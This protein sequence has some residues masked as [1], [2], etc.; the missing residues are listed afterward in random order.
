MNKHTLKKAAASVVLA[1]ALA[2]GA[3]AVA[4]A[5]AP[6]PGPGS[7]DGA[8]YTIAPNG[9]VTIPFSGFIPGETVTVTLTGISALSGQIT[10]ASAAAGSESLVETTSANDAGEVTPVVTVPANA[11]GTYTVTAVGS[12]SGLALEAT[13]TIVANAGGGAGGGDDGTLPATGANADALLGLWVGGGALLLAGGAVVVAT[14]VRR[15]RNNS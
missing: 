1:G 8:S 2:L 6:S 14:S 3:P 10:F 13:I 7:G 5:Y 4:N 15:Q 12:E 9:T 11:S